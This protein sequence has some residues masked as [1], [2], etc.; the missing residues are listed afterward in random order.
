MNK[1]NINTVDFV[2][3]IEIFLFY[4]ISSFENTRVSNSYIDT[5][6]LEKKSN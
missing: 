1:I 6:G 5:I 4:N 3:M 2:I